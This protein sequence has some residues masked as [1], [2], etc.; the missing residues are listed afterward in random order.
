MAGELPMCEFMNKLL[1]Q[2][3]TDRQSMSAGDRRKVR[4]HVHDCGPCKDA[5]VAMKVALESDD[6][7][8]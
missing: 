2:Y 5:M 1:P 8:G 7:G 3:V 6:D 4:N